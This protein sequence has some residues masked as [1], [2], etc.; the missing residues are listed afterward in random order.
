MASPGT[1]G[2][3]IPMRLMIVEDNRTNLLVLTRILNKIGDCTVEGYLDPLEAIERAEAEAFD[4]VLVDFMMPGLDWCSFIGRLRK[5]DAYRHI[6][7]VMI[8]ADGNRRTRIDSITV[9]ATNFL[10]KPVDPVELKARIG[11]LLDL[12]RAQI[13]L[14]DRAEWLAR[15]VERATTALRVRE[16]EV[17]WRLSRALEYRD[18]DTGD[19]TNRVARLAQMIAEELGFATDACRRGRI[20]LATRVR[21]P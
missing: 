3:K 11:N 19:H 20:S 12:R 1:S 10:N 2:N 16:E 15:G 18:N 6:P 5:S 8:T 7:I 9:G 17:I 21:R 4:F 14:A 13:A